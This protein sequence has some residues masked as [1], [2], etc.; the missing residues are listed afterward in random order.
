MD[1]QQVIKDI[2]STILAFTGI[3]YKINI[4]EDLDANLLVF[5][6]ET[7][8]SSLLIGRDGENLRALQVLVKIMAARKIDD[9]AKIAPFSLDVN[10]Y[11]KQ[12]AVFLKEIVRSF[13]DEVELTKKPV[14]LQSMSSF[15]RRIV[16]LEIMKRGDKL[17]T[18]SVGQEPERRVVIKPISAQI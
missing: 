4:E 9:N 6:I 15:E 14:T 18:E 10:H 12:R 13:A 2:I 17:T 5:D 16:H 7:F 3:D 1:N 8:D 11:R